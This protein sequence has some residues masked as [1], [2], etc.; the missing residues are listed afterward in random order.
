MAA[1]RL[2]GVEKGA[3]GLS[4]GAGFVLTTALLH[5]CGMAAG[6]V[7]KNIASQQWMRFAG[8]AIALGGVMLCIH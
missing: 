7:T 2:R 4:Y 1:G 6:V 3:A 8:A 5:A